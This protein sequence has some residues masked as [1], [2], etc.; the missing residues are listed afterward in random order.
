MSGDL[1]TLE[2]LVGRVLAI[3]TVT[4]GTIL[5]TG[6]VLSFVWP[7][8]AITNQILTAG[9][10]VL[11]FTPCFYC[12]VSDA[13]L[14]PEKSKRLAVTFAGASIV[15]RNIFY[16]GSAYDAGGQ[17]NFQ[18]VGGNANA[19]GLI[20]VIPISGSL[21]VAIGRIEVNLDGGAQLPHERPPHY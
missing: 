18:I 6:L 5:L 12:N 15:A 10:L 2:R 20:R 19:G 8:H 11:F 16:K 21:G 3:G 17:V 7:H 9:I 1:R 4:S 13:W 14:F